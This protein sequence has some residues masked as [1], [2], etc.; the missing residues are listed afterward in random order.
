MTSTSTG[1][2]VSNDQQLFL[3][4]ALP[5]LDAVWNVARRIARYPLEAEDLVQET[6][7]RAFA[8]FSG[9]RREDTRAWL[10]AICLNAARSHYR[11][12]QRRPREIPDPDPSLPA[13]DDASAEAIG[14]L[15]RRALGEALAELPDPQ[16]IAI[17]LMDVAGLTAQQAA[18]AVG[19]PR[20]TILA[21][22]HRGRRR[23]AQLLRE[24]DAIDGL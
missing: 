20:G 24:K 17:L 13:E 14:S 16:R 5:H 7:L 1:A 2:N 10:I 4:M 21:R 23:L 19:S 18:D 11:R 12:L 3:D 22:V 8:G 15:E 6:Y 9:H